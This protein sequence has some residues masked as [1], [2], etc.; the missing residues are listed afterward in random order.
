M[1]QEIQDEVS[2]FLPIDALAAGTY[3]Y[4]YHLGDYSSTSTGQLLQFLH[5]KR[6]AVAR[7]DPERLSNAEHRSE[8]V[9]VPYMDSISA[10]IEAGYF[11]DTVWQLRNARKG[12]Y[13]LLYM[14]EI[15]MF[16]RGKAIIH[17]FEEL[18]T[19]PTAP[20]QS[21]Q[22]RSS[23][24]RELA[25]D[26]LHLM[27]EYLSF[28]EDKASRFDDK[29]L[30]AERVQKARQYLA[31]VEPRVSS[32]SIGDLS[33]HGPLVSVLFPSLDEPQAADIQ[34]HLEREIEALRRQ[35]NEKAAHLDASRPPDAVVEEVL[36]A[37]LERHLDQATID[38]WMNTDY[39]RLRMFFPSYKLQSVPVAATDGGSI[40]PYDAPDA[41]A[42]KGTSLGR[43][44]AV[45]PVV[46]S[47]RYLSPELAIMMT[48]FPGKAYIQS[49]IAS[50]DP[51]LPLHIQRE[52]F[53]A[54]LALFEVQNIADVDGMMTPRD[55]LLT[56]LMLL[57]EDVAAASDLGILQN[58]LS[59]NDVTSF[60]REQLPLRAER[61]TS[62]SSTVTSDYGL[63]LARF[64]VRSRF[65][66]MRKISRTSS[67]RVSWSAFYRGIFE[68]GTF[69]PAQF[70]SP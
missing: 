18:F 9:L 20:A 36:A 70:H 33:P 58:R 52:V 44:Q 64:I 41:L 12:I 27:N 38:E 30:I 15:P 49:A 22:L 57:V 29:Q 5:E 25:M 14:T 31:K 63:S 68:Q 54:A 65:R 3:R 60:L 8:L 2:Y 56:T 39:P 34:E 24:H 61:A 32:A 23:L 50:W 19:P 4:L 37:S 45:C 11:E 10:L 67:K 53:I 35:L 59:H 40:P 1:F 47:R 66:E 55:S 62:F 28:A 69:D 7:L 21:I 46:F 48:F 43:R 6:E 42:L 16:I 51:G 17:R 13:Q 26:E